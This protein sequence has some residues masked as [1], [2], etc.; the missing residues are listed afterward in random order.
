VRQATESVKLHRSCTS[1]ALSAGPGVSFGCC[2]ADGRRGRRRTV[3][4]GAASGAVTGPGRRCEDATGMPTVTIQVQPT[5]RTTCAVCGKCTKP[6]QGPRLFLGG[7]DEPV[8]RDCG[9]R[10]SPH[11]VALLDLAAVAERVG[12]IGRHTLI[13]PMA[14]LL[15]LARAAEMYADCHP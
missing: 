8:C 14:A 7:T 9:K 12:H 5:S 3:R 6:V 1:L 13:P 11:L 2:R 10:H 4:G 15:D